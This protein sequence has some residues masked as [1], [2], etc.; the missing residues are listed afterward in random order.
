[1]EKL[2]VSCPNCGAEDF[3]EK[4][5]KLICRVCHRVFDKGALFAET[6]QRQRDSDLEVKRIR[7]DFD[8]ISLDDVDEM[9]TA[10]L[11]PLANR[12]F[13]KLKRAQGTDDEYLIDLLDR[14]EGRM[15]KT[16][17]DNEVK[18]NV[19][20]FSVDELLS[21]A[22]KTDDFRFVAFGIREKIEANCK[23]IIA[24]KRPPVALDDRFCIT[25]EAYA[26]V[27][28]NYQH[29]IP[30][31]QKSLSNGKYEMSIVNRFRL[32]CGD[33]CL[34]GRLA[35]GWNDLN[36]FIHKTAKNNDHIETIKK[37]FAGNKDPLMCFF[38]NL[39]KDFKK[40]GLLQ[41]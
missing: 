18:E 25:P 12:I 23:D 34:A 26:E 36:A 14:V 5:G 28:K 7:D 3:D 32:C 15:P 41:A 33:N 6:E 19:D 13:E 40:A 9:N 38:T 20:P 2:R 24:A 27:L 1:M 11:D 37:R 30:P 8:K 21:K 35:S 10:D 31:S 4:N 22:N 16:L 29:L 39:I 17:T